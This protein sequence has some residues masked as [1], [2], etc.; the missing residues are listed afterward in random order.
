[1]P[2]QPGEYDDGFD[3]FDHSPP[4]GEREIDEAMAELMEKIE[5]RNS[6]DP[7]ERIEEDRSEADAEAWELYDQD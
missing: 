1:M 2:T 3:D 4:S 6:L 5:R 7:W